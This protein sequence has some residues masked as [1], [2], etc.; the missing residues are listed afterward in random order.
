MGHHYHFM[1]TR[2]EPV[3]QP[4]EPGGIN[5]TKTGS[6]AINMQ[7]QGQGR[8]S[9][10]AANTI[11]WSWACRKLATLPGVVLAEAASPPPVPGDVGLLRMEKPGFHK[12]LTTAEN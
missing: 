11:Q 6:T 10:P 1:S 2:I 12:Y 8:A 5:G 4:A 9:A 7:E 3:F